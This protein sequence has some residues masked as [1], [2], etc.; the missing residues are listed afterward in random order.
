MRKLILS[1]L[2]ASAA[3]TPALAQRDRGD[4]SQARIE[5]QQ[6]REDR[7]AR[8]DSE[9]REERQVRE[10]RREVREPRVDRVA[11]DAPARAQLR[12]EGRADRASVDQVR[13][14]R[15]SDGRLRDL[16]PAERQQLR[17]ERLERVRDNRQL[18]Q[19]ERARPPVLRDR[20]PV[21]ST[22]PRAGTQPPARVERRNSS[23]VRWSSDWR[24]NSRYDWYNYRNRNRSLFRL[25]FYMDPFG[26]GYQPYSIGWRMWPG[27][28]RSNYWLNDPWQYRL[29]YAPAGTR[30]VRYYNDAV[31]VDTWDG[32][33]VD[34]IY[35]FFW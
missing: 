25:G 7:Q 32:Q 23:P 16:S 2:M 13:A 26:W 21:V 12:A 31:L 10:A 6:E 3:A 28:Y 34:V 14:L 15:Q 19:A 5:R 8:E 29:P 24:R 35:N 22:T 1:L 9:A 11:V 17:N 33:V 30:W 18:R 27:Y 20:V 4:R